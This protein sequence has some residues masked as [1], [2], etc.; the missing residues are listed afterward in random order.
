MV[1]LLEVFAQHEQKFAGVGA[2]D[3]HKLKY[4]Y[5]MHPRRAN[6]YNEM[7]FEL[8]TIFKLIEMLE[9][10]EMKVSIDDTYKKVEKLEFN[11]TISGPNIVVRDRL[12]RDFSIWYKPVLYVPTPNSARPIVADFVIIRGVAGS[13]YDLDPELKKKL[14]SYEFMP[15]DLLREIAI[16]LL[17]K[18]RPVHVVIGCKMSFMPSDL[19]DIKALSFFLKPN[20]FLIVSED[21]LPEQVKMNLPINIVCSENVDMNTQ[22]FVDL[23]R[24]AI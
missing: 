22:K 20:R 12:R 19:L 2:C 10:K 8:R 14:Y 23:A 15:N 9:P 13:L 1:G 17:A 24:K 4:V 16:K 6:D 5:D 11:P 7:Q 21:Y 3:L 18:L